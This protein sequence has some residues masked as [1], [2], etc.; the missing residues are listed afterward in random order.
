MPAT[1]VVHEN[2]PADA[3]LSLAGDLSEIDVYN[4][5]VLVGL[6]QRG[7]KDGEYKTPGGVVVP[8][9]ATREDEYQSKVGIILKMG[10]RAF[11]DI[12]D[13]QRW[14]IDQEMYD[15]DW[16]VFRPSDGWSLTL[17]SKDSNGKMKKLLCRL[18]DD[19]HIMAKIDGPIGP[20]RVW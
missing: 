19:I 8:G 7:D 15:H 12:N 1:L 16:V 14:F 20:D 13:P 9:K 3:I 5:K 17:M 18:L 4:N 11:V 6:Y 10:P 2:D